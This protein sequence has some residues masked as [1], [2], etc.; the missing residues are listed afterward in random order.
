MADAIAASGH[1]P[2]LL[3]RLAEVEQKIAEVDRQLTAPKDL[4]IT[5]SVNEIGKFVTKELLDIRSIVHEDVTKTKL[6]LRRHIRNLVLTPKDFVTGK[7]RGCESLLR[8][9]SLFSM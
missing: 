1:S 3:Y 8:H 4:D 5:A 7:I 9:Q 2:T 6:A